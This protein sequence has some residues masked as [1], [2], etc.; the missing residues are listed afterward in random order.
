M[1]VLGHHTLGQIAGQWVQPQPSPCIIA[2][3]W[4]ALHV[5]Y[6]NDSFMTENWLL[7]T[8]LLYV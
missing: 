8:D 6:C 2:G 5:P 7:H 1:A 4:T 3:V